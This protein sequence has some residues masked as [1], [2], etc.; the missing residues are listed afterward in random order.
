VLSELPR[1]FGQLEVARLPPFLEGFGSPP[2]QPS[3]AK[4]IVHAVMQWSAERR[5]RGCCMARA[6]YGA[7]HLSV[8]S[9]TDAACCRHQDCASEAELHFEARIRYIN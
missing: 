5:D 7:T 4:A 3:K 6:F 2:P 1:Y 8:Y 9:R